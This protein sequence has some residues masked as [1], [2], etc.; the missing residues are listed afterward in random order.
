MPNI[1]IYMSDEHNPKYSS[2]YGNSVINTPNM[3]KLAKKGTVFENAYCPSPLCRPSRSAFMSGRPDHE[4][5][6]YNNCNAIS[7]D[8]PT[9]GEVLKNQGIYTA[10]T[11]KVDIYKNAEELGFSE[12][13]NLNDRN[14]PGDT[15]ISRKPL[16]IREGSHKRANG[17]GIKENPFQ[18]DRETVKGAVNWLKNK[19]SDIDENWTLTVNTGAPHFPQYVTEELWEMY[20]GKVDLPE[21]G[22]EC[23]SARHPYAKDLRN[24]FE[25]D[26]FNEEQ[27]RGLRQGYYG[28]VTY[29]DRELGRLIDALEESGQRENTVVIYTSDHGEMLGKFGMWW[30]CSLYEDSVR[31]PLIISGPGFESGKRIKTSVNLLDLQA[32]IFKALNKNYPQNWWGTPLQNINKNDKNKVTFAEYHGHG[33]RSSAYMLRK[34]P[35]KLLYNVDAPHQLFNL[36]EDPEELNNILHNEPKV[37]KDLKNELYNICSPEEES[38]KVDRFIEKQLEQSI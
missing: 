9:Y 25:T 28:C 15:N 35:W 24:H 17:Y 4:V 8:Y 16:E 37:F 21:Y 10:Y 11:G 14:Q 1:L 34:G 27:T 32:A 3:E 18:G 5:Q 36:E 6:A 33:V 23:R 26:Y 38:K 19:S 13:F 22:G 30:K 20:E 7:F 31:V 12:T 2:V 29:V